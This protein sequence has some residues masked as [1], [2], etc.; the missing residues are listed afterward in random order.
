VCLKLTAEGIVESWFEFWTN[1]RDTH[2]EARESYRRTA[3]WEN[4]Y[5]KNEKQKTN[6]RSPENAASV[7][8]SRRAGARGILQA[9]AYGGAAAIWSSTNASPRESKILGPAWSL[10]RKRKLSISSNT[11]A[12]RPLAQIPAQWYSKQSPTF[13]EMILKKKTYINF[14]VNLWGTMDYRF[15]D[16]IK[17]DDWKG[18]IGAIR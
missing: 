1:N 13:E 4:Q 7:G 6:K 12:H 17:V 11:L 16:R 15:E 9:N 3:W 18:D 5:L 8:V 2:P 10:I 14:G